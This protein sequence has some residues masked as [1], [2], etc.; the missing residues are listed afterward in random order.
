MVKI[1]N[2]NKYKVGD[3]VHWKNEWGTFSWGVIYEIKNGWALV[4]EKGHEGLKSGARLKDC[5][6]DYDT[7]VAM[8]KKKT[9][10]EIKEYKELIKT[11]EDLVLFLFD[12]DTSGS[13][14]CDWEAKTAAKERAKE[15]LGLEVE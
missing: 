13:E 8:N 7:C 14:Y 12:H 6:P 3:T 1:E 2:N 9:Q 10:E 15:L 5:W 11:V 4:Y